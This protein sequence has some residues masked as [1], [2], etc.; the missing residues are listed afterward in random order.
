MGFISDLCTF[1]AKQVM[2]KIHI[3]LLV[4]MAVAIGIIISSFGESSSYE[5]FA[6]AIDNPGKEYHVVGTLTK[7]DLMHY[8]PI[9]D[10]NYFSFFM[11]DNDGKEQKVVFRGTK[12]QDFDRSEQIVLV[13]SMEGDQFQAS[14]ILTKCPS[15]Y[16]ED[17]VEVKSASSNL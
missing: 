12:P 4:L 9:Q 15:K 5:S 10:A 2:K 17:E 3:I 16:T 7:P 14:K 1:K 13:G 11:L 8:D 6:K